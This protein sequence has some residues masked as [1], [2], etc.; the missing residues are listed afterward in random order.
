MHWRSHYGLSCIQGPW[1]PRKFANAGYLLEET[2]LANI[3]KVGGVAIE[4][5]TMDNNYYFDDV[6]VANDPAVAEAF[7]LKTWTPK[8]EVEVRKLVL[9]SPTASTPAA[10]P[11]ASAVDLPGPAP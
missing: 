3:G 1:S 7:R 9:V 11:T 5:W 4:I 8:H 2:P 10:C 6:V